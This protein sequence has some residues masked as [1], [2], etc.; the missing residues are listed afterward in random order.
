[1]RFF[2]NNK[3]IVCSGLVALLIAV[4]VFVS[5]AS[6]GVSITSK[7]E[8]ISFSVSQLAVQAEIKNELP[9]KTPEQIKAAALDEYKGSTL[10]TKS[11]NQYEIS[12]SGTGSKIEIGDSAKS[13]DFRPDLTISQWNGEAS[14]KLI[15]PIDIE[16][17]SQLSASFNSINKSISASNGEWIF[18]YKATEPKEGFNDYGGLDI[19]IT[20]KSKPPSNK[21]YFTY[22]SSTVTPYLQP[23][24]TQEYK[25][26]YSE[27]FQTDIKVTDTEVTN[28][29]TGDVLT[30]RPDYVVNSIAFYADGKSNYVIGGINY[31]TGKV[32]HLYR[33][34][35]NGEWCDW[36]IVGNYIV[37]NIPQKILDTTTYPITIQP[38]GDTFGYTS[39]GGTALEKYTNN[40]IG[41]LFT[42]PADISTATV[43]SIT[44]WVK[45]GYSETAYFKG[46][47]VLQSNLN[48]VS[49]GTGSAS[50]AITGVMGSPAERTSDF[51][52]PPTLSNSTAYVIGAVCT[53]PTGVNFYGDTVTGQ[54]RYQQIT[55]S[56]SSPSNPTT[57]T[58]TS[59]RRVSIY[60]TYTSSASVTVTSIS[61]DYGSTSG[62]ASVN[63]TG[64]GFTDATGATIGGGAVTSFSVVSDTA[65]TGVSP[66][67]TARAKDVVVNAT[68]GNGTLVNGFYYVQAVTNVSTVAEWKTNSSVQSVRIPFQSKI[69]TASG[70]TW[71]FH[72]VD[73]SMYF[74]S[75][76]D[77]VI[78]N[79]AT[80]IAS[81]YFD[82]EFASHWDGT[83]VTIVYA[84]QTAN[85]HMFC[86]RGS[87]Q[88]D[89]TIT[90]DTVA[91]DIYTPTSGYSC[92]D[93]TLCVNS[94]GYAFI[95]FCMYDGSKGN[96]RVLKNADNDGTWTQ[97][98]DTELDTR[99]I[100]ASKPEMVSLVALTSGKV[101]GIYAIIY[102][103]SNQRI[104]GKLW[105]SG[106]GAEETTTTSYL[107]QA[108]YDMWTAISIGDDVHLVFNEDTT[109][110]L[111]YAK[112]TYGAGTPWGNEVTIQSATTDHTCPAI[113]TNGSNLTV[114][115]LSISTDIVYVKNCISDSWDADPITVA[116]ESTN[117]ILGASIINVTQNATNDIFGIVYDICVASPYFTRYAKY[118]LSISNTPSSKDLGVVAENTT[119]YAYGT[120]PHNPVV[121]GDCT[122]SISNNGTTSIDIDI[123]G[124]SC[125]GGVGWTLNST[126]GSDNITITTYTTGDNPT[127][128]GVIVTT[129][130]QEFISNLASENHTHWDFKFQTGQFTDAATKT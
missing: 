28:S 2:K 41:G 16:G 96:P 10:T 26:G 88:S 68:S 50:S 73:N 81:T 57:A 38:L 56:Y 43:N 61:P 110:D 24:L 33:M 40:F 118:G 66:S 76:T 91:T 58:T 19:F 31:Q 129:S 47:M 95:G 78:W 87:P 14:F 39:A 54:T 15:A 63:I 23:S 25:N 86:S 3:K 18:E 22:D 35:I 32:G 102:A 36:S 111:I 120:A 27:E 126:P 37:L 71:V 90:W 101:Y 59:N 125:T 69:F 75:S 4:T 123:H 85:A 7:G 130:D 100:T 93:P 13:A 42:S 44:A 113:S 9:A 67:G 97:D 52:T 116:D 83:H 1:M 80:L 79:A 8:Y 65:I 92:A 53:A 60:C 30:S 89:G 55:N 34:Q 119:Y 94:N 108:Y 99:G 11:T 84:K 103:S 115:W 122:F 12:Y 51:A 121:D 82:Y 29:K 74:T 98:T 64:T 106:W 46:M 45:E 124:H 20:A 105:D 62:G 127:T 72:C 117:G 104:Y 5:S 77:G 17:K 70:R 128:D 48:I 6:V 114:F 109:S 112:R 21:I 107:D 49:N